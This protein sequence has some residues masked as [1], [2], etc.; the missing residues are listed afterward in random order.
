MSLSDLT[1]DEIQEIRDCRNEANGLSRREVRARGLRVQDLALKYNIA[2]GDVTRLTEGHIRVED[3][4]DE[5]WR[6]IE[7]F[8]ELYAVSNRG[9][10]KEISRQHLVAENE[11][12]HGYRTVALSDSAANVNR[13]VRRSVHR[14]VAQAFLPNPL[15]LPEVDHINSVVSDNRVENLQWVTR[16]ENQRRALERMRYKS[17]LRAD[18]IPVIFRL[19][20]Q[21]KT[22]MEIAH[23]YSVSPATIRNVLNRSSWKVVPVPEQDGLEDEAA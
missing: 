3:L 7:G 19:R 12:G 4:P 22:V 9:R 20:R 17:K 23:H 18:D 14:I 11:N 5:S 6:D 16:K 13:V 15:A 21:G 2:P 10:V 8:E 1:D